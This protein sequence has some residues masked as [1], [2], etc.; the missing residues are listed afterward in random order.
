MALEE[1]QPLRVS[2]VRNCTL[3][4]WRPIVF[5]ESPPDSCMCA[6]C[7]AVLGVNALAC[8]RYSCGHIFCKRCAKHLEKDCGSGCPFDSDAPPVPD[9]GTDGNWETRE[10]A[11]NA[12]QVF[13]V[14][15][16]HGCEFIGTLGRLPQHLREECHHNE[17]PCPSCGRV[18]PHN[19][20]WQHSKWSCLARSG[21]A[22]ETAAATT[23][24][25]E[26]DLKTVVQEYL[27]RARAVREKLAVLLKRTNVASRGL[28]SNRSNG[29]SK[30]V[31]PV[32]V[33]PQDSFPTS[34]W[35]AEC[36]LLVEIPA[37]SWN[38]NPEVPSASGPVAD[39]KTAGA[40][41]IVM[42]SSAPEDEVSIEWPEKD[43]TPGVEWADRHDVV[44]MGCF[45]FKMRH[46]RAELEA[47]S[48]FSDPT[49]KFV[50]FELLVQ[51]RGDV[52][53]DGGNAGLRFNREVHL[54]LKHPS[55]PEGDLELQT[56]NCACTFAGAGGTGRWVRKAL[57]VP[58][59]WAAVR[60]FVLCGQVEVAVTFA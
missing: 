7:R 16:R 37:S 41:G 42:A 12:L 3:L 43:D 22:N 46:F 40:V 17:L 50:I 18:L 25:E 23:L 14:N 54:I 57:T 24:G 34:T 45:R 26:A 47:F 31:P 55:D 39:P 9:T 2:G 1:A 38:D 35:N 28:A 44:T 15:A 6:V 51:P 48:C 33:S 19:D 58:A 5:L 29:S 36:R 11:L 8:R 30:T 49:T 52:V 56:C 53:G 60:E 59:E 4:E 21:V 27:E 10:T 13:C 32:E 20:V